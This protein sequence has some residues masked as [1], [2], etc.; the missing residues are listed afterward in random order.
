MNK[1]LSLLANGGDDLG[2]G[3]SSGA[4]CDSGRKVDETSSIDVPNFRARTTLHDERGCSRIGGGNHGLIAL[5]ECITFI[6]FQVLEPPNG[7]ERLGRE[8][9]RTGELYHSALSGNFSQIYNH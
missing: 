6:E 7:K 8:K 9:W 1:A 4:D 5:E 3:M 2:M